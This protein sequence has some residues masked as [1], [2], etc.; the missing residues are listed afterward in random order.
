MGSEY[1]LQI[2]FSEK[3]PDLLLTLEIPKPEKNK[4]KKLQPKQF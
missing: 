2:L 3:I 4:Q 1:I